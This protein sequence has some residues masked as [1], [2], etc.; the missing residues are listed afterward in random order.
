MLES[1]WPSRANSTHLCNELLVSLNVDAP[2]QT[3]A[4]DGPEQ[5]ESV[6]EQGGSLLLLLLLLLFTPGVGL[7]RRKD[8]RRHGPADLVGPHAGCVAGTSVLLAGRIDDEF[9]VA[10]AHDLH[11]PRM[12]MAIV[13]SRQSHGSCPIESSS[14]SRTNAMHVPRPLITGG[15]GHAWRSLCTIGTGHWALCTGRH[16]TQ[17]GPI[18]D[19]ARTFVY[20]S[21]SQRSSRSASALALPRRRHL[22]TMHLGSG[23]ACALLFFTREG[24]RRVWRGSQSN[25][26][27]DSR[28]GWTELL[29]CGC[30][31]SR[32]RDDDD[33]DGDDDGSMLVWNDESSSP[34]RRSRRFSLLALCCCC[35]CPL[36]P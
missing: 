19:L 34:A 2:V 5:Q 8:A 24:W 10:R 4:L 6:A 9:A 18:T 16:L 14:L 7:A 11:A 27:D 29:L 3:A 1:D 31:W 28:R 30:C 21:R 20:R 22:S 36:L 35:C 23:Y 12:R 25:S 15:V 33:D 32:Q 17:V 13:P 26:D